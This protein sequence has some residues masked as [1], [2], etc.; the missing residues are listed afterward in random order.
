MNAEETIKKYQFYVEY[1]IGRLYPNISAQ[2][3]DDLLQE[4][5]IA[6]YNAIQT[7]KEDE[8]K[9]KTY[10][11]QKIKYA[12]IDQRGEVYGIGGRSRY[13]TLVKHDAFPKFCNWDYLDHDSR[14]A[15]NPLIDVIEEEDL[16]SGK[17]DEREILIIK[18]VQEGYKVS[19]ICKHLGVA[20]PTGY[21]YMRDLNSKLEKY[22]RRLKI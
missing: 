22:F 20:I 19:E 16:L 13:R 5:Y 2:Q 15:D 12:L 18:K 21:R 10:V 1:W 4:G 9:F 6:I 17:L 3:R 7:Y 11:S 14:F 8:A